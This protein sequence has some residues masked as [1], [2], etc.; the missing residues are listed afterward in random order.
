MLSAMLLIPEGSLLQTLTTIG[1]GTQISAH[2]NL[3]LQAYP[4]IKS[5]NIINRTLNSRLT[6]LLGSLRSMYPRIDFRGLKLPQ[7]DGEGGRGVEE[8]DREAFRRAVWDA[9]VIVTATSSREAL[10]PSQYVSPGTHLCLIGSY[11]PEMS[12]LSPSSPDGTGIH[13]RFT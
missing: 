12:V 8:G 9:D 5:C 1:A 3:F 11:T 13:S 6:T 7:G 10:F 4:S 2:I